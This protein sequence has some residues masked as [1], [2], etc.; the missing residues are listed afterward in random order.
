V[1][2][3][4]TATLRIENLF[5]T[6]YTDAAGFNYDFS[7]TDEA[8]IQQTGYRGAARRVLAGVRLSF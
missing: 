1:R 5:D 3:G 7:R 8:S 4:V 6:H 2:E